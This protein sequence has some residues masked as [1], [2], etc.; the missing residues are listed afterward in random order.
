M[1]IL[2]GGPCIAV[3]PGVAIGTVVELGV[4]AGGLES[5]VGGGSGVSVG[6]RPMLVS[7]RVR[8]GN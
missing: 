6:A 1:G 3:R 5:S 2:A 8:A 7:T 4:S